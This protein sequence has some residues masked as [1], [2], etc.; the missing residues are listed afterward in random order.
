MAL[1]AASRIRSG[2]LTV[3]EILPGGGGV[4][5]RNIVNN[6]TRSVT[7]TGTPAIISSQYLPTQPAW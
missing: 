6:G 2:E 3:T 7:L 5:Q 1:G 4:P